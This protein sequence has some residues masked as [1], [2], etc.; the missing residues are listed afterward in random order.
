MLIIEVMREMIS[1]IM[2]EIIVII[3]IMFE[4]IIII[5]IMLEIIFVKMREI[6]IEISVK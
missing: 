2:L 3:E 5:E 4:I 6:V 1:E